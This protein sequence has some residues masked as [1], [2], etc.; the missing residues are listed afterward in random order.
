MHCKVE[1]LFDQLL[2]S[3]GEG[4]ENQRKEIPPKDRIQVIPACSPE[5]KER[6]IKA[7]QA[8]LFKKYGTTEGVVFVITGVVRPGDDL[9]S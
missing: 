4:S 6:K 1:E 9:Q 2:T 8:D 5:G 3:L 7:I